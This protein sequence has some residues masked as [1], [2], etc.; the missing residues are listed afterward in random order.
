[1]RGRRGT[2]GSGEERGW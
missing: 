2:R 1:M